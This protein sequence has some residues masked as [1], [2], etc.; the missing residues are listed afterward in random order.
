MKILVVLFIVLLTQAYSW[1]TSIYA[2]E[3]SDGKKFFQDRPCDE[4]Q[5]TTMKK[6]LVMDLNRE[7]LTDDQKE[8]L[9]YYVLNEKGKAVLAICKSRLVTSA[10]DLE[11]S[12]GRFGVAAKS[13]IDEGRKLYEEGTGDISSKSFYKY[14]KSRVS[15]SESKLRGLDIQLTEAACKGM[16]RRYSQ[17]ASQI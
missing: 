17:L 1:G 12:I 10:S 16:N 11:Y 9:D 5:I 8:S 13:K 4:S 14:V 15:E 2:C 6:E 3:S 7:K